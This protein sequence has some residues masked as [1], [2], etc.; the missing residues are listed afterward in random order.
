MQEHTK[1]DDV[2]LLYDMKSLIISINKDI[3]QDQKQR[4]IEEW[5]QLPVKIKKQY[6]IRLI[7][8]KAIKEHLR[9]ANE[10]VPSNKYGKFVKEYIEKNEVK[11][12]DKQFFYEVFQQWLKEIK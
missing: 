10:Y 11:K 8:E 2:K 12:C 7:T 1:E 5:K 9:T 6:K 4:A 3:F